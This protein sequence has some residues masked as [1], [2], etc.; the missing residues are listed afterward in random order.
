MAHNG[1]VVERHLKAV[2]L[3]RMCIFPSSGELSDEEQSEEE[4]DRENGN[5]IPPSERLVTLHL[6][7]RGGVQHLLH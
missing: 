4:E 5:H 7:L 3:Y 6:L 2:L 1:S